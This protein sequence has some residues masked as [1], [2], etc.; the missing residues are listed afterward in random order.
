[1][2]ILNI[3]QSYW[4][5]DLALTVK[6]EDVSFWAFVDD[7]SFRISFSSALLWAAQVL[8]GQF[9]NSAFQEIRCYIGLSQG[10]SALER[11]TVRNTTQL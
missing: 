2:R 11:A 9:S 8:C 6:R 3:T 5:A 7:V 1:M 4:E 10:R